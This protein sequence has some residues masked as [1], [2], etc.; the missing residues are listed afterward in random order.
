[1]RKWVLLM[2][3]VVLG[4]CS[5]PHDDNATGAIPPSQQKA[6][7]QAKA[8]QQTLDAAA[9]RQQHEIEAQESQ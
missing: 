3:S 4:A 9:A 8:V 2:L 5:N 1:M 6:L 7:Q